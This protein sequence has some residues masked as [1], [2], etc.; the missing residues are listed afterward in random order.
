MTSIGSPAFQSFASDGS[1]EKSL[2]SAAAT[3]QLCWF[4]GTLGDGRL[5]GP[6][7]SNP[8]TS[9]GLL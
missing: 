5:S 8:S 9:S 3:V 1:G 2:S 4:S 7:S 6:A